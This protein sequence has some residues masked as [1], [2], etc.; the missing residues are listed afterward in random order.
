MFGANSTNLT[1]KQKGKA[2]SNQFYKQTNKI[3]LKIFIMYLADNEKNRRQHEKTMALKIFMCRLPVC[4]WM[5]FYAL[6]IYIHL[7]LT[8]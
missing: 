7:F 4:T 5:Y 8:E 1:I 3:E 2:K 6:T